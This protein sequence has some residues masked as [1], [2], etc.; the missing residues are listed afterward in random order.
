MMAQSGLDARHVRAHCRLHQ[1]FV[2][3]V[4]V[5]WARRGMSRLGAMLVDFLT[6]WLGLHILGIDRSMARQI[7]SRRQGLDAARLRARA[8]ARKA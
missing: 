8:P 7:A 4:R 1:Q 6:A 2:Q 3:Q 5:M